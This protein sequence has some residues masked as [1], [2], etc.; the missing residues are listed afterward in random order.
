VCNNIAA[1]INSKTALTASDT[2]SSREGDSRHKAIVYTALARSVGIP[3]RLVS[4]IVYSVGAFRY[5][6]WAESFVG[7]WVPLDP[8]ASDSFVDALHIKLEEHRDYDPA[9]VV[10]MQAVVTHMKGEV[11]SHK[12]G[13][14]QTR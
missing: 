13:D 12:V 4:G 11:L 8:E 9:K 7:S 6:M 1:K 14:V 5:R 10:A 2:L 3:T